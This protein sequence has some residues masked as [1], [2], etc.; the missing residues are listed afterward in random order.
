MKPIIAISVN[1]QDDDEVARASGMGTDGQRMDYT[2][3]DYSLAVEKAGGIPVWVP[4]MADENDVKELLD[5]C[6]GVILSGGHDV[7]PL[8]Y[9][10]RNVYSGKISPKRDRQDLLIARYALEKGMN[11]L[12]ICRGC[13]ILN[14]ACGGTLHQDLE[15]AGLLNH[16]GASYPRNYGW[17][18]INIESGSLLEKIFGKDKVMVNSFH[19][20]AIKTPGE[21]VKIIARANID[22]ATE[23]IVVNGK[24]KFALGVQWHPEMMGDS[25]EQAKIFT[26][27]IDACKEAQKKAEKKAQ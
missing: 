3:T 7:D 6:D 22:D 19:H 9:N 11:V 8:Q 16:F 10:D 1:Y 23:G 24:S 12:G 21:N 20:Q 17:H 2:A 15:Q 5:R 14:V 27:F 4:T 25:D 18:S 26:A 13:Q